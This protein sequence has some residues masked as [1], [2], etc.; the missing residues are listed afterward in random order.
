[1]AAAAA[2]E[3]GDGRARGDLISTA[4]A[5]YFSVIIIIS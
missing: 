3:V 5:F 4:A 1:M 2:E